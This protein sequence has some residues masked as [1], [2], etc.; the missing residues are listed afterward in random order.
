MPAGRSAAPPR[1]P[2]RGTRNPRTRA[3]AVRRRRLAAGLAAAVVLIVGIGLGARV[4]VYDA[5]LA[6]VE[7]IAVTGTAAIAVTEVE[8][9]AAVPLAVPLAAV[10]LAAVA[11]R[12]A[13]LPEVAS[14]RVERDWPHTVVIRVVE[15]EPVAVTDTPQ[16]PRLV[17]VTGLPYRSAPATS[18]LPRLVGI[19]TG[20]PRDP[21]TT[22][23]LTVLLALP[24]PV[25]DEVDTVTVDAGGQVLLGLTEGR[26]V[27]WGGAERSPDKV[28]VLEPLLTEPGSVYDV[29]SPELPTV[30][31]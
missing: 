5:G 17:D 15:R 29:A 28:R 3:A 10:D 30:R 24:E 1:S 8:Q 23:A 12:V 9:A 22:A 6:D 21:A 2:L 20:G 18:E 26:E 7:G 16:G 14:V 19:G 13:Q 31:R 4:L 25:R 11:A 27:R